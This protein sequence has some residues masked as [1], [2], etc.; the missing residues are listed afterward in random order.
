MHDGVARRVLI[1]D[2]EMG[3]GVGLPES[4]DWRVEMAVAAFDS[5]AS[6]LDCIEDSWSLWADCAAVIWLMA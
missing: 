6:N 5:E 1:C 3:R 4:W 2:G